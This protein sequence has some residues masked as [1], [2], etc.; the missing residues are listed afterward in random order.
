METSKKTLLILA[1]GL[2]SRYKG[3][4]QVE[5]IYNGHSILEYSIFDAL[6]AGFDKFVFIINAQVPINFIHKIS[7]ILKD[8]NTEYHWIIQEKFDFVEDENL[9]KNRE[10]P[11]GTGQAVLCTSE[12]ITENFV[13]I[14]ADDLYG[15][16]VYEKAFQ[17]INSGKI[18]FKNYASIPYPLKFTVSKNGSVSRGKCTLNENQQLDSVIELFEIYSNE[19]EI[20]HFEDETKKTLDPETLVSMNF[21]ILHPSFFDELKMKF[22]EFLNNNPAPKSEFLLPIIIDDLI[23]N[24]KITVDIEVS[25]EVWKG[26]TYP[27]DKA[28]LQEFI[29][30]KISQNIYPENLWS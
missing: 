17:M 27:D 30:E 12:V 6:R 2:G 20:Y 5:G 13:V 16:S 24:Q 14:N 9:I 15:K 26:I 8:R 18:N 11:W 1:G 23:K 19:D 22:Q 25:D 28:E 7:E 10:K 3:L 21:W 4:K 29:K